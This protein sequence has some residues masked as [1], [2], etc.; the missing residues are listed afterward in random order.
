MPKGKILIVD[1]EPDVVTYLKAVL[2]NHGFTTCSAESVEQGLKLLEDMTPDLVCLDIMMPR[3]LGLTLYAQMK[4]DERLKDIPVLILSGVVQ[5]AEFDFRNFIPDKS[6]P[7]PQDYIEKP[8]ER[9]K[10]LEIVERII[11]QSRA[12]LKEGT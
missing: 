6:V 7:R 3:Q 12:K 9:E 8:I 1:D 11:S 10:F 2:E 4:K 5:E